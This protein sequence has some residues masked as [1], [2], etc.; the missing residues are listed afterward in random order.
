MKRS[1]IP[2]SY[3]VSDSQG[4]EHLLIEGD[5][6][7]ILPLLQT[8]YQGKIDFIYLDPPYNT[9]NGE[10]FRYCNK[11]SEWLEFM[12]ERLVLAKPLMSEIPVSIYLNQ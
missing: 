1:T 3:T 8:E 5:N 4:I 2:H 11:R 10:G 12:K 7:E 6:K 9:G